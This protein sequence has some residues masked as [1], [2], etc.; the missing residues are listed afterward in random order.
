MS[1]KPFT[2]VAAVGAALLLVGTSVAVAQMGMGRHNPTRHRVVRFNGVPAPYQLMQNPVVSSIDVIAEG[3]QLFADNCES[4][5]GVNGRGEGEAGK[6]LTP[7]APALRMLDQATVDKMMQDRAAGM[8]GMGMGG[9]GSG[10]GMGPGMGMGRGMGMGMGGGPAMMMKL[11]SSDG[12]LMWSISEGGEALKTDMPAFK[13]VLSDEE[14][15]KL[16]TFIQA[17]LPDGN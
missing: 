16:V 11:V 3:R 14:R 6:D 2:S 8:G 10:M 1:N 4:C 15:W 17:N 7:P 5:H 13:D 9:M 12:F